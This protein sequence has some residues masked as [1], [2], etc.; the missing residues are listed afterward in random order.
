MTLQRIVPKTAEVKTE[1]K[2]EPPSPAPKPLT[3]AQFAQMLQG[4]WRYTDNIGALFVTFN[5]DGTFSTVR[6][7]KELR[8][9]QKVFVQSPVSS[10]TWSVAN[11]KLMFHVLTSVH[12]D[13]VNTQFNFT[14]RSISQQDFIFVDY[15][16]RVGQAVRVP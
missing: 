14:V 10:G 2:K 15:L 3:D 7:V 11:G 4:T 1:V 13:R 16:G 6:E 9:F 8:L 5:A 12:P